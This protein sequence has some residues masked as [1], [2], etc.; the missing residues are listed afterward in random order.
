MRDRLRSVPSKR[1]IH[2][3]KLESHEKDRSRNGVSRFHDAE[4]R[5]LCPF[6]LTKNV[7]HWNSGVKGSG[8][9]NDKWMKEFVFFGMIVV[10]VYK[11]TALLDALS[12]TQ[13]NSGVGTIQSNRQNWRMTG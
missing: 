1:E 12:S 8:E 7:Y 6:N 5:L 2:D 3:D 11:F 10:P 13:F 4:C 9:K